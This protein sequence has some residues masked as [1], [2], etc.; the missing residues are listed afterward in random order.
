MRKKILI[1]LFL[2]SISYSWGQ[3]NASIDSFNVN[4]GSIIQ[5]HITKVQNKS[6]AD[7]TSLAQNFSIAFSNADTDSNNINIGL[8][9]KNTGI[10]IIPPIRFGKEFTN[11]LSVNV[12]KFEPTAG[13]NQRKDIKLEA[14]ITPSNIYYTNIPFVYTLNLY[15]ATAVAKL[16]LQS[17]EFNHIT[18]KKIGSL[19]QRTQQ[20]NGTKY[21]IYAQQFLLTPTEAGNIDLHAVSLGGVQQNSINGEL[22]QP[23]N[24]SSNELNLTVQDF[25]ANL[26]AESI[27]PA[28]MV[29]VSE[30]WSVSNNNVKT[31]EPFSRSLTVTASGIPANLIANLNFNLPNNVNGYP[32]N[33][34]T[35][36]DFS[37]IESGGKLI[38]SKVFKIA[39]IAHQAG[40]VKF[41]PITLNWYD[42]NSGKVNT[43]KIPEHVFNVIKVND[44]QASFIPNANVADKYNSNNNLPNNV[45]TLMQLLNSSKYLN[46]FLISLSI[47]VWLGIILILLRIRRSIVTKKQSKI[48]Q[49]EITNKPLTDRL[50]ATQEARQQIENACKVQ[51]IHQL[52]T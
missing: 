19:K 16:K 13:A 34:I 37:A 36:D 42:I 6:K 39:Y 18:I 44:N 47:F 9:A 35:N 3:V 41:S 33:I 23:F 45:N 14:L 8:I 5:L 32:E 25:P 11:P 28:Q 27:F 30:S 15:L 50:L 51:D 2:A 43:I 10:Q 52:N 12:V 20:I 1:V 38:G 21:Y 40:S 7:L 29:S 46:I 22:D 24:I 17:L 31:G 49:N 4:S 48:K 26:A